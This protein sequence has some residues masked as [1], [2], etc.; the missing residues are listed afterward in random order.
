MK[1][2]NF[3]EFIVK[4][5][6]VRNTL[7]DEELITLRAQNKTLKKLVQKAYCCICQDTI[8]DYTMIMCSNDTCYNRWCGGCDPDNG[9]SVCQICYK[10]CECGNKKT[11]ICDYNHPQCLDCKIVVRCLCGLVQS[12][13]DKPCI[14]TFSEFQAGLTCQCGTGQCSTCRISDIFD[15]HLRCCVQCDELICDACDKD[16]VC[17]TNK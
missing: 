11:G 1:P 5:I 4:S 3:K 10:T 14:E 13:C 16:H 7:R 17:L 12:N 15:N 8:D 2:N 6:I 9:V